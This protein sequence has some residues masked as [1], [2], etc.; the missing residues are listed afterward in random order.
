ME[1]PLSLCSG[2]LEFDPR[3][4]V[5][6]STLTG[7][8]WPLTGVDQTL[9]CN[10]SNDEAVGPHTPRG[11]TQLVTHGT[12]KDYLCKCQLQV[13]IPRQVRGSEECQSKVQVAGSCQC[14]QGE[15]GSMIGLGSEPIIGS[16][17]EASGS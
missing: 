16:S 17:E 8:D 2:R 11:T 9:T 7:V 12:T 6:E 4:G 15:L 1:T 14:V 3:S 5:A 10:V 13:Q